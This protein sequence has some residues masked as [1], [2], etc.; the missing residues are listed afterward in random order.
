[1]S[2]ALSFQNEGG[3]KKSN[4]VEIRREGLLGGGGFCMMKVEE[5]QKKV[6][7]GSERER[8]GKERCMANLLLPKAL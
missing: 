3:A 4:L 1:M 2:T 5:D 6:E 8:R 7:K